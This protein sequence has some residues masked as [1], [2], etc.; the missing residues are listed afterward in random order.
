LTGNK[1]VSPLNKCGMMQEIKM[2]DKIYMIFGLASSY[3]GALCLVFIIITKP[4]IPP[5]ISSILFTSK[6]TGNC[7]MNSS[8]F[9]QVM[10]LPINV[11]FAMDA[12]FPFTLILFNFVGS[13]ILTFLLYMES[14]SM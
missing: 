10:W 3:S 13:S 1:G 5:F 2:C 14:L 11:I 9:L 7:E 8:I 12:G 6:T 4:C